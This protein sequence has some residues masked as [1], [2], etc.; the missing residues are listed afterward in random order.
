[1]KMSSVLTPRELPQRFDAFEIHGVREFCEAGTGWCEQV[2]DSEAQFWSLYGHV[3][4]QGFVCIGN[5]KTR[6]YAEEVYARLTGRLYG[7]TE[8]P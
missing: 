5:F 4:G 2:P 1:M 3:P 6:R 8:R 7:D